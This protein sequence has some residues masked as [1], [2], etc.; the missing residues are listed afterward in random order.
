L[1]SLNGTRAYFF[2]CLG[3]YFSSICCFHGQFL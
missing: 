2:H 1:N 3:T